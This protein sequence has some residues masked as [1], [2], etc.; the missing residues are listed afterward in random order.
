MP[1]NFPALAAGLGI[2]ALAA[3]AGAPAQA[4]PDLTGV[5]QSPFR[6]SAGGAPV[7]GGATQWMPVSAGDPL[8]VKVPSI[9][10]LVKRMDAM[11]PGGPGAPNAAVRGHVGAD[12]HRMG[13]GPLPLT[14]AG[15]AAAAKLDPVALEQ[16]RVA[17][18]P[19]NI[20]LRLPGNPVQIVQNEKAISFLTEF[21]PAGRTIFMDGR[22][23][24]KALPQW[25][26]HSIG[27]WSGD[28]LKIDTVA[29]RGGLFGFDNPMSDNATL[30]EEYHLSPD[31][32]KMIGVIT[33]TD[34]A[35]Y[36]EPLRKAVY[37]D[38]KPD[39]EVLDYQCEEGK[40]DMIETQVDKK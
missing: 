15:Q 29:L 10:E 25:N 38:R 9:E 31:H 19:N 14:P 3:M 24:A 28:T 5:W 39:M 6:V 8:K 33:F 4:H 30:H 32:A 22:S 16:K 36:T 11:P 27:H 18:Y 26:G 17:C 34:P 2:C 13:E 21:T 7:I 37:L 1:Q 23:N 40:D 20:F 12:P 35:Y